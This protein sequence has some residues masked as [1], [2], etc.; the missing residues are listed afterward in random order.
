MSVGKAEMGRKEPVLV[1]IVFMGDSITSG[2]Y[3]ERDKIW[4]TIVT[5]KLQEE[6]LKTPVNIYALNKGVGDDT[7]R[8]ALERFPEDVQSIRPDIVT[9]Q[10]GMNDCNCWLSDEGLPRVSVDAFRANMTEMVDRSRRFGAKKII[11][12]GNHKTLRDKTMLNGVRYEDANK[13]YSKV[14]EA[15]ATATGA[16]FCDIRSKFGAMQ[17]KKLES[18][19]LPYPDQ[20]HLSE[21]G[22]IEYAS[23]VLDTIRK[24][25]PY[26][27]EYL[28]ELEYRESPTQNI[29]IEAE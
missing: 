2:E 19:L 6:Y 12:I 5:E 7:T 9:I 14:I 16:W 21:V 10:F 27:L 15:V 23:H 25:M 8:M 17:D 22:H 18:M 11:I 24:I 29:I 13:R 3:I 1:K 26:K 4:T 20:I 28:R